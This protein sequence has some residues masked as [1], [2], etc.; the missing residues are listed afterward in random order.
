MALL[1]S[2]VPAEAWE[3]YRSESGAI[4]RWDAASIAITLPDPGEAIA[5]ARAALEGAVAAWGEIECGGPEVTV[6][7][8]DGALD[9]T[10]NTN[11]VV[12]VTDR[13]TWTARFPSTELARTILIYRVQSGRL[14]D[15][16]IAVN[17]AFFEYGVGADCDAERY[18]LQGL[19]TH[20]LGHVFGL[21]HSRE[22]DATMRPDVAPGDC[23]NRTLTA[24]DRAGYCASYP[25]V[26]E[27]GPELAEVVE[28]VA[29]S[30]EP[31]VEVE[32]GD[33]VEGRGD[34]G[35]GGG[36]GG[37]GVGLLFA[38]SPFFRC[39]GRARRRSGR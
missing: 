12:W 27:P 30:D 37:A 36:G 21:D 22:D 35:C 9:G 38:L 6:V 7:E 33:Q 18:D 8:G 32:R 19:F 31:S 26:S 11:T 10:D 25:R 16:D 3:V 1:G 20:E 4:L 34:E 23:E 29:D 17:L 39:G 28:P 14:V 15:T 2:A 24:D 13:D 5:R